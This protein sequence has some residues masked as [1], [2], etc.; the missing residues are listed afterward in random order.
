MYPNGLCGDS[1]IFPSI[2]NHP[3]ALTAWYLG[4]ILK[5]R[6]LVEKR[7]GSGSGEG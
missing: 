4:K 1:D 5:N 7:Y 3:P 6:P 2:N